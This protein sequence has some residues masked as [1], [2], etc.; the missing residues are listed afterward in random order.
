M[1][2]LKLIFTLVFFIALLVYTLAF[3]ARNG[4]SLSVDFLFLEPIALPAS[5][6]LGLMLVLGAVL[7]LGSGAWLQFRHLLQIRKL[8][9]IAPPNQP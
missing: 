1:K 6:W 8:K 3:A 9:K 2:K 4:E 7:G 5:L